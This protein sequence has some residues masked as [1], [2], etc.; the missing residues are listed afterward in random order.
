MRE[1]AKAGSCLLMMMDELKKGRGQ[2]FITTTAV[3][4]VVKEGETQARRRMRQRRR[5]HW[6][7]DRMTK[8]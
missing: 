1:D 8:K 3:Y 5:S 2:P 6:H 7:I 4:P